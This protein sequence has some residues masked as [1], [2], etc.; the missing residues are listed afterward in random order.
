MP[1]RLRFRT[2]HRRG[3]PK[4]GHQGCRDVLLVE[5]PRNGA[6]GIV[7]GS[8][9]CLEVQRRVSRV[10]HLHQHEDHMHR[11]GPRDNDLECV[12][13]RGQSQPLHKLTLPECVI[14]M[15]KVSPS[16][17]TRLEGESAALVCQTSGSPTP[18]LQWNLST[19]F[20]Y[21]K[22]NTSGLTS[23]LRLSNLSSSD[24]GRSVSC[25]AENTVGENSSSAIL[26]IQFAPEITKLMDAVADHHWCIPFSVAGNPQP[27]LQWLFNG[28]DLPEGDY[29]NTQ[30]HA[31][32]ENE[33]HGCLQLDNPTHVNNGHYTLVAR[34]QYGQDQ[35]TIFSHF[36]K[37]PWENGSSTDPLYYAQKTE[38]TPLDQEDSAAVSGSVILQRV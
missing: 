25:T 26:D 11:S 7:L 18:Q 19:L 20:S 36:M 10:L 13:D 30:I 2:N 8:A 4:I 29:I 17:I 28:N 12:D 3:F 9:R 14:P 32:T 16:I 22:V 24:S 5:G 33:Y 38:D 31:T 1:V 34:N 23:E 35:K 27:K 21:Y 6:V 37:E 15:V